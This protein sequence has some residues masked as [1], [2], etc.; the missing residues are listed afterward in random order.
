VSSLLIIGGSGFFGKSILDAYHRGRLEKWH[1]TRIV[2]FSRNARSLTISNPELISESVSLI[3][4]DISTC[5]SLPKADY[6]IHAAASSDAAK[7]ISSPE[8]EKKNILSGTTN[9]CG[10]ISSQEDKKPKIL[11]V[12]SGAVYGASSR[13]GMPFSE[14]DKFMPLGEIDENKRCYSAAKRDSEAQIIAL[15]KS[16]FS[17]AI[18]RCFAFVG[19]YLPRDQHFAIGNF[20]RD[21][22]NGDEIRVTTQ[23]LVYRSYMYADELV[24][25]LMTI[26]EVSSKNCPVYNVGS[27]IPI[28]VRELARKVGALLNTCVRYSEPTNGPIDHYTPAIKKAKMELGL[29]L[30]ISLDLAIKLTIENILSSK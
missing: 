25:W 26:M 22:L 11:Y 13:D 18:A 24:E 5:D 12:S 27:N 29:E 9:F 30:S 7:Y 19:K 28:E 3:N 2:I 17:V 1:I 6:I 14:S 4:G 21:A 23:S 8:I 20:M 15:G 16:G 10:L